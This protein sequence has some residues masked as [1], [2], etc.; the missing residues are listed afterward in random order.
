MS[1]KKNYLTFPKYE[2]I[3]IL[4]STVSKFIPESTVSQSFYLNFPTIAHK[5][6]QVEVT[7]IEYHVQHYF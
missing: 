4:E 5:N 6:K 3:H 2:I 7:I 1:V